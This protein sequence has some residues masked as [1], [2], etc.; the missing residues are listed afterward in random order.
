[1]LANGARVGP[2]YYKYAKHDVDKQSVDHGGHCIV[3]IKDNAYEWHGALG[4]PQ[5]LED[6]GLSWTRIFVFTSLNRPPL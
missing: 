4:E 3:D 1:M 2:Q 5:Q 6:I